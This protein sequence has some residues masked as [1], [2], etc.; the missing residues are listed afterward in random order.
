[1]SSEDPGSLGDGPRTAVPGGEITGDRSSPAPVS[2]KFVVVHAGARDNFQ[3]AI[4]LAER[5]MLEFLVTDLFW[6]ADR[7]WARS[8]LR[9]LPPTWQSSLQQRNH[10]ELASSLVTT[11]PL[12]GLRT[13]LSDRLKQL[14]FAWRRWSTRSSDR[15]LGRVAGRLARRRGADLISYSYTGDSAFRAFGR[16]SMLFQAHPHPATMRRILRQ[17]L[18]D[19]PDCA[20]SLEQEWELALPETEY[21]ALVKE[22]REAEHFLVASGFTRESLI[23]NGIPSTS[24]D[25][26]PYGIDLQRFRPD[27]R[28]RDHGVPLQL[29]FVGRI[30]QRKGIKY[31]LQALD[32]LP[33]R[34]LH[35][36]VCG[37]VLDD[38]KIFERYASRITIRPSVSVADLAAAYQAADLFVFPSVGE[39]FGQV[40]LE[41]LASGLPILSTTRTA[42]PDLI[43]DGVEGFI[44]DPRSAEQIAARIE[45]ALDHREALAGMRDAARLRAEHF[46]W[47]R[48]RQ[49]VA[50]AVERWAGGRA[51]VTGAQ[52]Q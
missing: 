16:P 4:A 26:V 24:I 43:T 34:D 49:D 33:S 6:P 14:P 23:E 30:N 10:P 28:P 44:V 37:R 27:N 2:T 40:L 46:T 8:L 19:H 48:F 20:A 35:L 47:A 39:G 17:E 21:E 11:A 42:A 52:R 9:R 25:V 50:D 18:L 12:T 13:L 36:T 15:H 1:M 29:L 31:L 3:L 41:S 7:A 45:W 22:S 51:A 38:L 32:L 5:G